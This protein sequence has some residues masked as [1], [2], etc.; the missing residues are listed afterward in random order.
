VQD[1]FDITNVTQ[2]YGSVD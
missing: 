1:V 2:L